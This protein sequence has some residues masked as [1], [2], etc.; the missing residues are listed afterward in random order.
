MVSSVHFLGHRIN[1]EGLH[2]L[3]SNVDAIVNAPA[4]KSVTELKAIL[5]LVNYYA[6]F[7]PN[8]SMHL[9]PLYQ[10]LKKDCVCG[11]GM[12]LSSDDVLV[13]YDPQLPL[14]LATDASSYGIG[15]V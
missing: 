2:P 13:Q 3:P 12:K 8:L 7:I 11:S 14:T 5:G 10:L 15:A 9:A 4:P 6:K 1:E